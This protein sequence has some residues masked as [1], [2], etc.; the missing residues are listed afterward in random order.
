[1]VRAEH[2]ATDDMVYINIQTLVESWPFELLP[3]FSETTIVRALEKHGHYVTTPILLDTSAVDELPAA[4]MELLKKELPALF[5]WDKG[6]IYVWPMELPSSDYPYLGVK[7]LKEKVV[8]PDITPPV[9]VYTLDIKRYVGPLAMNLEPFVRYYH[10][11]DYYP[12]NAGNLSSNDLASSF[13]RP[14]LR[15]L[16]GVFDYVIS[17]TLDRDT[18]IVTDILH[19]YLSRAYHAEAGPKETAVML[20]R[21]M[22][23]VSRSIQKFL[24]SSA[25]TMFHM[26]AL[27]HQVITF[28]TIPNEE[29][30]THE[31]RE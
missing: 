12:I 6:F 20:N 31:K 3:L 11:D 14:Q 17:E 22:H 15:I 24:P 5:G 23:E 28:V 19:T 27:K 25:K 21:L 13:T 8:V 18:T 9:T 30:S 16:E 29:G 7:K 1:M 4:V 10:K 26:V 2:S